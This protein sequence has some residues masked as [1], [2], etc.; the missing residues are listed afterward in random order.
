MYTK[1]DLIKMLDCKEH[2]IDQLLQDKWIVTTKEDDSL[3]EFSKNGSDI[4]SQI[5]KIKNVIKNNDT[6][7]KKRKEAEADLADMYR[8]INIEARERKNRS[9]EDIDEDIFERTV[10]YEE[11]EQEEPGTTDTPSEEEEEEIPFVI[12]PEEDEKSSKKKKKKKTAKKEREM[13]KSAPKTK[14]STDFISTETGE[15]V[16]GSVG[17][18][19]HERKEGIQE[20]FL[21]SHTSYDHDPLKT[22]EKVYSVFSENETNKSMDEGYFSRGENN[23]HRNETF[24]EFSHFEHGYEETRSEEIKH[25]IIE[26]EE[27]HRKTHNLAEELHTMAHTEYGDATRINGEAAAKREE[28][29]TFGSSSKVLFDSSD[30]L[31]TETHEYGEN[32]TTHIQNHVSDMRNIEHRKDHVS[33]SQNMGERKEQNGTRYQSDVYSF[34]TKAE[35]PIYERG[36]YKDVKNVSNVPTSIILPFVSQT[37]ASFSGYDKRE[38]EF[39]MNS[40]LD[41]KPIRDIATELSKGMH[42]QYGDNVRING[43]QT[44]KKE[45]ISFLTKSSSYLFDTATHYHIEPSSHNETGQ[46]NDMVRNVINDHRN[47]IQKKTE[48]MEHKLSVDNLLLKK[49]QETNEKHLASTSYSPISVSKEPY[50]IKFSSGTADKA[51]SYYNVLSNTERKQREEN[52]Y[53]SLNMKRREEQMEEL[54]LLEKLRESHSFVKTSSSFYTGSKAQYTP[55]TEKRG[56]TIVGSGKDFFNKTSR[57]VFSGSQNDVR[58]LN[59]GQNLHH[60]LIVVGE[61]KKSFTHKI[62]MGTVEK[63]QIDLSNRRYSIGTR[64]PVQKIRTTAIASV[65]NADQ[66]A[67]TYKQNKIAEFKS[68]ALALTKKKRLAGSTINCSSPSLLKAN[69]TDLDSV[70]GKHKDNKGHLALMSREDDP[71]ALEAFR[72][73]RKINM[74]YGVFDSTYR[75]FMGCTGMEKVETIRT[76]RMT[77]RKLSYIGLLSIALL[78][79]KSMEHEMHKFAIDFDL[80]KLEQTLGK[81]SALGRTIFDYRNNINCDQLKHFMGNTRNYFMNHYGVDISTLNERSFQNLLDRLENSDEADLLRAFKRAQK[82]AKNDQKNKASSSKLLLR[83][84]RVLMSAFEGTDAYYGLMLVSRSISAASTLCRFGLFVSRPVRRQVVRLGRMAGRN[85]L[86]AA[87]QKIINMANDPSKLG[88]VAANKA[89]NMKEAYDKRMKEKAKKQAK[90]NIDRLNGRSRSHAIRARL[91]RTK[92]GRALTSMWQRSTLHKMLS[93]KIVDRTRKAI[94]EAIKHLSKKLVSIL[95]GIGEIQALFKIV[96]G[97]IILFFILSYLLIQFLTVGIEAASNSL[98]S[99]VSNVIGISSGDNINSVKDA[100]NEEYI[101][102]PDDN[103]VSST[104]ANEFLTDRYNYLIKNEE[105]WANSVKEESSKAK[106]KDDPRVNASDFGTTASNIKNTLE[107][108]NVTSVSRYFPDDYDEKNIKFYNGRLL[109]P[110]AHPSGDGF[111]AKVSREI[112]NNEDK[113]NS[114]YQVNYCKNAYPKSVFTMA[115]THYQFYTYDDKKWLLGKSKQK[116]DFTNYIKSLVDRGRDIDDFPSEVYLCEGCEE[117]KNYSCR[118]VGDDF[119]QNEILKSIPGVNDTTV[120]FLLSDDESEIAK[121]AGYGCS[122]VFFCQS[123]RW[124]P[125]NDDKVDIMKNVIKND[126]GEDPNYLD[127]YKEAKKEKEENGGTEKDIDLNSSD[128][129]CESTEGNKE[130]SLDGGSTK[131]D[132]SDGVLELNANREIKN[133]INSSAIVENVFHQDNSVS[134]TSEAYKAIFDTKFN[135]NYKVTKNNNLFTSIHDETTY[136][137]CVNFE[138]DKF[139]TVSEIKKMK[140]KYIEFK[141][142]EYD[143]QEK[144]YKEL[145]EY[146]TKKVVRDALLK[147]KEKVDEKINELNVAKAAMETAKIARDNAESEKNAAKQKRSEMWDHLKNKF[148]NNQVDKL[149]N[150]VKKNVGTVYDAGTI[151]ANYDN[152][153]K[154]DGSAKNVKEI[155]GKTQNEWETTISGEKIEGKNYKQYCD[156]YNTAKNTFDQADNDYEN[157][158]NKY[159]DLASQ[160]LENKLN[161]LK[162]ALNPPSVY[163]SEPTI[164]NNS[165]LYNYQKINNGNSKVENFKLNS[166]DKYLDLVSFTNQGTGLDI[167]TVPFTSSDLIHCKYYEKYKDDKDSITSS[168]I[169]LKFG[170][171]AGEIKDSLKDTMKNQYFWAD[172]TNGAQYATEWNGISGTEDQTEHKKICFYYDAVNYNQSEEDNENELNFGFF[173]LSSAESNSVRPTFC[174]N[175]TAIFC[176]GHHYCKEEHSKTF[177]KGHID[178]DTVGA[179]ATL[180]K[181]EKDTEYDQ[182]G[183]VDISAGKNIGTKL[184]TYDLIAGPKSKVEKEK[185]SSFNR[186]M[187]TDKDDSTT[188]HWTGWKDSMNRGYAYLLA[189]DANGVMLEGYENEEVS[190]EY[191]DYDEKYDEKY[192]KENNLS[193]IGFYD[194]ENLDYG[195]ADKVL[196]IAKNITD[197]DSI[198][199][200]QNQN[201]RNSGKYYDCSSFA[202]HVYMAATDINIAGTTETQ[203][204][205]ALQQDNTRKAKLKRTDLTLEENESY[206]PIVIFIKNDKDNAFDDKILKSGDLIYYNNGES[207]NTR[208]SAVEFLKSKDYSYEIGKTSDNI[209][210][211]IHHVAIFRQME[212]GKRIISHAR[213]SNAPLKDQVIT[214]PDNH[215]SN[216]IYMVVRPLNYFHKFIE[217]ESTINDFTKLKQ[218]NNIKIGASLPVPPKYTGTYVKDGETLVNGQRAITYEHDTANNHPQCVQKKLVNCDKT[219]TN[220]SSGVAMYQCA[221]GE[222]RYLVA[223]G[224]V[225]TDIG[226]GGQGCWGSGSSAKFDITFSSGVTIKVMIGDQ[227]SDNHTDEKTHAFQKYDGSVMEFIVHDSNKYTKFQKTKLFKQPYVEKI[228]YRGRE[229]HGF[230][231]N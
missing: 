188:W 131:Y 148:E 142:A 69:K 159:D 174:G 120:N 122:E 161:T 47:V 147:K 130:L 11:D 45:N 201:L 35:S 223:M 96:V 118:Y 2:D 222:K 228:V 60:N 133:K 213:T 29:A 129:G 198:G 164:S 200:S 46:K 141:K 195:L 9:E 52:F 74:S 226:T 83:S 5:Q 13:F 18:E 172:N 219:I 125:S 185:V 94:K 190:S 214:H 16:T 124:N 41:K 97:V 137:G 104:I 165:D 115:L 184:F 152:P 89:I 75:T 112:Y 204:A 56:T 162:S 34:S 121:H 70:W 149:K 224:S 123:E 169:D 26:E 65:K 81:N 117:L 79:K 187:D 136:A 168:R 210:G 30:N 211:T 86:N 68:K 218:S 76:Y 8:E 10:S 175:Y 7:N 209:K 158:K 110:T 171:T 90:K 59:S 220:D 91:A 197:D 19:T 51:S 227:K 229:H 160:N 77:A 57:N 150:I 100:D 101:D 84:R 109:S 85:V 119:A 53:A 88:H 80:D 48:I 28:I 176:R 196:E 82:A 145:N 32:A 193:E 21:M 105:E 114:A 95:T 179:E 87:G 42:T 62:M 230:V 99:L 178:L 103:D 156:A 134:R 207:G 12:F 4:D 71:L 202:H 25:K 135:N 24:T 177:C 98:G 166:D 189:N 63:K 180:S 140:K 146:I 15:K 203:S 49:K 27:K 192:Q 186:Y 208:N 128:K 1:E 92:P 167:K 67:A 107:N 199:Y 44:V 163:A 126:S 215:N 151:K 153:K 191:G 102:D 216:Q 93:L 38:K 108:S 217:K 50:S 143:R 225:Y 40:L 43:E 138:E 73:R 205:W 127:A 39:I 113:I 20:S 181:I 194:A 231:W 33:A 173:K 106:P 23:D 6:L 154:Q 170:F 37:E 78:K 111:E 3:Y 14:V 183:N 61:N 144:A 31:H 139:Y 36:V 64:G 66:I 157:K 212:D 58:A 72:G 116:A 155:T 54:S 206:Y 182:D 17:R 55:S 132:V 221:N 22:E